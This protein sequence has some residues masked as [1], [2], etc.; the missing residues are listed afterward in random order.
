MGLHDL[1]R[2]SSTFFDV[3]HLVNLHGRRVDV[4]DGEVKKNV[5]KNEKSPLAKMCYQIS[6]KY[7]TSCVIYIYIHV[8]AL[9]TLVV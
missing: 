8:G 2:D 1:L 9:A 4:D 7:V 3:S 5:S 6:R